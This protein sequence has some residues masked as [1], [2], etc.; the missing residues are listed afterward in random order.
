MVVGDQRVA[1]LYPSLLDSVPFF[2]FPGE[3]GKN[4]PFYEKASGFFLEKKITRKT[5]LIALGGGATG[6]FT[7][8]LAAT[9]LRG[10]PWIS[11]PT[12]LLAQ[13]DASIGGKVGLNTPQGKNLLGAFHRPLE[14][15]QCSEFLKSLPQEE[16]TSGL[17]EVVKTAFLSPKVRA[18]L[19]KN[20]KEVIEN[21]TEFKLHI[22]REDFEEKNLRKILNLG[23]TLGHGIESSLGLSH[24]PSVLY[25]ILGEEVFFNDSQNVPFFFELLKELNLELPPLPFCCP[26]KLLGYIFL[27]K[28]KEA[29]HFLLPFKEKDQVVLK[30]ISFQEMEEKVEKKFSLF[31]ETLDQGRSP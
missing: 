24:G 19:G 11:I 16:W 3:S 27:D 31:L 28:K 29:K 4:L 1:E 7:G 6:D 23:H 12:T 22:V 20:I 9:L 26:Q 21:C 2:P 17:G 8:F 18:S 10:L 15:W 5:T 13:V 30:E 25:G 14:I